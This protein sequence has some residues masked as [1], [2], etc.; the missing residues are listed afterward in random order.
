MISFVTWL[1][2]NGH[3]GNPRYS[4]DANAVNTLFRMVDRHYQG[5]HRK[6]VVT[7][8]AQGIDPS[9]EIVPDREDF[10]DVGNPNGNHNPSCFRR[11]RAFAPDA[12]K[13]F[14]E[15]LV[16]ID[17][18]VVITGD[19]APLFDRP[20]DFIIW[21]QS[22]YP[23]RQF[24]NGSLW[25]LRTGTRTKAWTDFNPRTSPH[26][27]RQAGC[28]GSD[29]GWLSYILGKQEARWGE[30][31]GVYSYRVHVKANKYA[32]PEN[33]RVVA[34]HGQEN[35]WGIQAQRLPWVQEYYQ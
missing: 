18:D 20:E 14:G 5:P 27:A 25:Y 10:K 9:I 35:P 8:L 11:L 19:L 32:L 6:I 34:F 12:G 23:K 22:D 29:Q 1:W 2:R 26:Q 24:F 33:A 4:F 16:S 21:G 15:R 28:K 31:D 3:V 13:T 17:L 7:N 30:K